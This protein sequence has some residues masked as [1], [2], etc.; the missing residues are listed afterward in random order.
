MARP[1]PHKCGGL[2]NLSSGSAGH[3]DGRDHRINVTK[4]ARSGNAASVVWGLSGV[5]EISA[6][7]MLVV[8]WRREK[9]RLWCL[10]ETM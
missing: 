7:Q 1:L 4:S 3:C 2:A 9:T 10:D 6:L 5:E 8:L